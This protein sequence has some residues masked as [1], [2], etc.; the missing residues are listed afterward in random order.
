M[1]STRP[2]PPSSSS[3]YVSSW[4]SSTTSSTCP[5]SQSPALTSCKQSCS[6]D[7]AAAPGRG[8]GDQDPAAARHHRLLHEAAHPLLPFTWTEEHQRLV[9]ELYAELLQSALRHFSEDR[10][11]RLATDGCRDGIG[12]ILLQQDPTRNALPVSAPVFDTPPLPGEDVA[13]RVPPQDCRVAA[14]TTRARAKATATATATDAA[15]ESAA[16]PHMPDSDAA[17]ESD[18]TDSETPDA[19]S[20]DPEVPAFTDKSF[21]QFLSTAGCNQH[22]APPNAH[23]VNGLAEAF[24]KIVG[25]RIALMCDKDIRA[26]DDLLPE[27][28]LA[29]NDSQSKSLGNT[30][31]YLL[32]G[33]EPR[34]P[35]NLTTKLSQ[36]PPA[37][38]DR[39]HLLEE[40]RTASHQALQEAQRQQAFQYDKSR[41][42]ASYSPGQ[43]VMVYFE[44]KST[45][46]LPHKYA[47]AW[48]EGIVTARINPVTY[49]VRTQQSGALKDKSVHV[50]FMKQRAA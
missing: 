12:C 24:C 34:H 25:E 2:S 1:T 20:P 3:S 27:I 16:P 42:P 14:V 46:E 30:P 36:D 22:T 5:D 18:N 15:D 32:H 21:Q 37:P 47:P 49:L 41:R 6:S 9:E 4:T 23:H 39:L 10:P 19:T 29:I 17:S 28:Q 45:P 38:E 44:Q 26:W 35:Q 7:P 33:Y 11:T 13:T 48:R 43:P 40:A 31:F 8:G 50:N